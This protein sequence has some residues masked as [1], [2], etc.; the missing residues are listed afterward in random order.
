MPP[1]EKKYPD[2]I[3]AALVG[4]HDH[5]LHDRLGGLGV[6]GTGARYGRTDGRIDYGTVDGHPARHGFSPIL[7]P[8]RLSLLLVCVLS[9]GTTDNTATLVSSRKYV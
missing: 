4:D 7:C 6:R 8:R 9:A 3:D 2:L 1:I 5:P